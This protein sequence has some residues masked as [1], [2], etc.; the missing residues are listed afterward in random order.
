[1][2]AREIAGELVFSLLVGE[3]IQVNVATANRAEIA[4]AGKILVS[5]AEFF[6]N[7]PTIQRQQEQRA[8]RPNQASWFKRLYEV[9]DTA[10]DWLE[11]CGRRVDARKIEQVLRGLYNLAGT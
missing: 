7:E 6:N 10:L 9:V 1:M 4:D 2:A 8:E 5:I 11:H 3:E